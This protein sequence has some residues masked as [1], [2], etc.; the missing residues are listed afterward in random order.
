MKQNTGMR[1]V[2]VA[3]PSLLRQ[4][5]R[6]LG[7]PEAKAQRLLIGCLLIIGGLLGFLP[8]LGFWMIP[9]GIM[10]IGRDIPFVRRGTACILA[11]VRRRR[12]ERNGH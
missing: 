2:L 10:L 8:V 6:R 3:V 9:L 5:Y 1:R 12:N 7:R 4:Q 11:F